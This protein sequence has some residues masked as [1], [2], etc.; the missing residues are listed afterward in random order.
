[1][2]RGRI[3][4]FERDA[5]LNLREASMHGQGRAGVG[6]YNQGGG[7]LGRSGASGSGG[8]DS[9]EGEFAE[10][11]V[12]RLKWWG[13]ALAQQ[14]S[15]MNAKQFLTELR[16]IRRI[17]HPNLLSLLGVCATN[18]ELL[19]VF[20]LLP[21]GSLDQRLR[22]ERGVGRAH[23]CTAQHCTALYCTVLYCTALHCTV[24]H[25][26]FRCNSSC[27]RYKFSNNDGCTALQLHCTALHLPLKADS[28]GG[29]EWFD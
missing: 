19:M 8:G 26:P 1:M 14:A 10:V 16:V 4:R 28:L 6:V 20:D 27:T 15:E 24:L 25:C 7:G 17:R 12:K 13:P 21:N 3:P 29:L 5:R 11:A 2:Y 18:G 9:G 23:C 22:G